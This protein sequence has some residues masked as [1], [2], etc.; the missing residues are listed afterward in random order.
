MAGVEA[1]LLGDFIGVGAVVVGDEA[2]VGFGCVKSRVLR[3]S[4]RSRP[5]TS[6][7]LSRTC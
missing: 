5:G 2:S 4:S 6:G 3:H 7:A 1:A